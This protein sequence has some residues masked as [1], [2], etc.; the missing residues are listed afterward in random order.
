LSEEV[1]MESW[2][3]N[4]G[5]Q[6]GREEGKLEGKLEGQQEVLV[7]LC[8]KRLHRSL[9]DDERTTLAARLLTLGVERLEDAFL[10]LSG[11]ALAAWLHD[12]TAR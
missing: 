10:T 2:V 11:E 7:R 12:T 9:A 8:E 4:Q 1:V 6:K 3:F 5:R